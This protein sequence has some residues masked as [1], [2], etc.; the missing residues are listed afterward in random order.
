MFKDEKKTQYSPLMTREEQ[1]RATT[2]GD[3][4]A[5]SR[6][7]SQSTREH[8]NTREGWLVA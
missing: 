8:W 2:R 5:T 1:V 3:D 4:D 7:W 6:R